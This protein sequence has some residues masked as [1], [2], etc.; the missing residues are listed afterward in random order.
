MLLRLFIALMVHLL[1]CSRVPPVRGL[2]PPVLNRV[3]QC[4]RGLVSTSSTHEEITTRTPLH[5][6]IYVDSEVRS[7]LN[8]ANHERKSRLVLPKNREEFMEQLSVD[9]VRQLVEKKLLKLVDQPYALRYALPGVMD[10]S[11]TF[12][13]NDDVVTSFAMAE[14]GAASGLNLYVESRPG[15]FPPPSE[16]YLQGMPDPSESTHYT[17]VSFYRFGSIADPEEF[18]QRLER[19]LRPFRAHGRV[20]VTPLQPLPGP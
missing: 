13:D 18:S 20:Y 10:N 4:R 7:Y 9:S 3:V 2:I 19:L 5:I 12:R 6:N 15:S 16:P 8:M 11:R 14:S 17:I 1:L